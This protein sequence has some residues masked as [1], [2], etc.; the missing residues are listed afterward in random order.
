MTSPSLVR[1]TSLAARCSRLGLRAGRSGAGGGRG[2]LHPELRPPVEHHLAGGGKRVRA[3]L[4]VLSAAA[5]GGRPEEGIVGAVAV[6]LVHNF[7]LIH[8]DIIDGDAERRHRPT[9]WVEFG[10]GPA[11]IAGDALADPGHAGP[12]RG[13]RPRRRPA[14][15][16]RLAEATQQMIAGQADDMAFERAATSR[17]RGVPEH[18]GG[19]DRSPARL[20]R[21]DRGRPGRRPDGDGRGAAELRRATWESPS[22]RWTTC[23][24]S[25]ASRRSP[26]SRSAA[27]CVQHKKSPRC[28]VARG[29]PWP[30]RRRRAADELEHLALWS[31]TS[32]EADGARGGGSA[33]RSVAVAAWPSSWPTPTSRP[34][35]TALARRAA[36][37]GP[38]GRAGRD[39]PLRRG[40]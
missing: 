37:A 16:P 24:A 35:W 33:A 38:A 15:R 29:P 11:I 13:A 27:T 1:A 18:G 7:S 9:V 34:R 4:A 6:E 22:R 3:A 10:V 31:E 30:D 28:R 20:R 36:R 26:A 23:S 17:V 32:T 2:R 12:P 39:R 21:V 25:G 8:D 19:Q 40:A 5:S 14:R